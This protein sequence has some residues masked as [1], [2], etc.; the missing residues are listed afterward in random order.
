MNQQVQWLFEAPSIPEA[1]LFEIDSMADFSESKGSNRKGI[2]RALL[3]QRVMNLR[4]QILLA[5][6]QAGERQ[7]NCLDQIRRFDTSWRRVVTSLQ[8]SDIPAFTLARQFTD[9]ESRVTNLLTCLGFSNASSEINPETETYWLFEVPFI[10]E[11]M[12]YTNPYSNSEWEAEFQEASPPILGEEEWEQSPVSSAQGKTIRETVS[13]FS[14]YSN[15]IPPQEKAKIL[16]L[17]QLIVQS[18]RSK[19]PIR[20]VR[21]VGHADR[22]VQRGTN[23]E[24]KISGDRAL[25]VQQALIRSIDN[26]TISSRINWQRVSA[27]ASQ[28]I[29]KNPTTEEARAQNRRVAALLTTAPNGSP[30]SSIKWTTRALSVTI[31]K[32]NDVRCMGTAS[33]GSI[34]LLSQIPDCV[35]T[36]GGPIRQPFKIWFHV[37]AD[38]VPRPKPFQPPTVSVEL[39][40]VNAS[41]KSKF[42][43]TISDVKPI[44]QGPGKPLKTSFGEDFAIP[45]EPGDVFRVNLRLRDSSSGSDVVY[46]DQI[47]V[48]KLPCV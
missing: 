36:C 21:L 1:A 11:A 32:P 37:D 29:V 7:K 48:V 34:S 45:I 30:P 25:V 40:V 2:D 44:Y 33:P 39:E 12:S 38:I 43:R 16:K 14:R 22:D 24:K 42:S 46:S 17:A 3:G 5:R 19:R 8:R 41:G 15:A 31:L 26:R 13:G 10:S 47:N 4:S 35:G 28:L 18:Y 27:G 9:L 6:K 23:F 20:T